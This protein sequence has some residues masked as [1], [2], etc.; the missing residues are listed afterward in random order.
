ME[1]EFNK[2]KE[3]GSMHWQEMISRDIGKFNAIQQSRYDWIIKTAGDISGRSVLDLGCGDGALTYLMAKIGGTIT[4]VDNN[5]LGVS[6]A[7]E[8]IENARNSEKLKYD[9]I[10]ASAY[11]LPLP[12]NSFDIIACCEVIEHVQNPEKLIEEA[13]RVLKPSGKFILTTPHR[14]RERPSDVNH[15]REYFPGELE[16]MFKKIFPSVEIKLFNHIFWQG[17]YIYSFNRFKHFSTRR[18][19]MLL[20]NAATLWFG[21]NPFM[22]DYPKP[23]KHDIFTQILISA[24]KKTAL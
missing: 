23:E 21:W 8:N 9:F 13:C 22:I 3:R 5:E 17:L 7:R 1:K 18:I 24:Q 12:D 16:T 2:Y 14:L 11:E 20:I 6:L 15:V 4:G 10:V 19:G